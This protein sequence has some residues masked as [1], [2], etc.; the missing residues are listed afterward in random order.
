MRRRVVQAEPARNLRTGSRSGVMPAERPRLRALAPWLTPLEL[1][2][3]GAI[4]G[5]SFLFMRVSARE[6]G[7]LPLVEIR[8]A[9][10]R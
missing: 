7:A 1:T 5:A 6:F 10:A 9:S 4:W 3:L 2:I 8:L